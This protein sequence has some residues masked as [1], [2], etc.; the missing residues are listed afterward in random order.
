MKELDHIWRPQTR[1]D[2]RRQLQSHTRDPLPDG[3]RRGRIEPSRDQREARPHRPSSVVASRSVATARRLATI[4]CP[5]VRR[6]A[7]ATDSTES[8]GG[9]RPRCSWQICAG[10][11]DRRE[12][13]RHGSAFRTAGTFISPPLVILPAVTVSRYSRPRGR[14]ILYRLTAGSISRTLISRGPRSNVR[15]E[16]SLRS[17]HDTTHPP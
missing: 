2:R 15:R 3:S 11:S 7:E 12:D 17:S 16:R 13:I 4:D 10:L 1:N 8:P 9:E 6:L 5:K 14:E